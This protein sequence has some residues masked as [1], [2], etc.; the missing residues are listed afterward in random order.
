MASTKLSLV[1]VGAFGG[2][3]GPASAMME[4]DGAC[5]MKR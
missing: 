2:V 4:I 3:E 5:K 1:E